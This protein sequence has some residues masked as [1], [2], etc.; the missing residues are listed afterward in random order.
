[1]YFILQH[2]LKQKV[3]VFKCIFSTQ[4]LVKQKN[5]V[6]LCG[7]FSPCPL[8]L[9]VFFLLLEIEIQ[10]YFSCLP[11]L[12]ASIKKT[13]FF[14]NLNALDF[15]IFKIKFSKC[16]YS[17]HKTYFKIGCLKRGKQEEIWLPWEFGTIIILQEKFCLIQFLSGRMQLKRTPM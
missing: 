1:M 15:D 7:L 2:R 4:Y 5:S 16:F 12:G 3:S 8:C 17:I 14:A 13:F 9:N 10:K 11:R 6:F